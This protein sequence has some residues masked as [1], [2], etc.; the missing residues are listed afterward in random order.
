MPIEMPVGKAHIS[1][2][3]KGLAVLLYLLGLSYGAV[4]LA[5]AALNVYT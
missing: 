1:L 4:S 2:Q 5:L 3:V